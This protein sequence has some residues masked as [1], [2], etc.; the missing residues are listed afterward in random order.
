M[1]L[2]CTDR[3]RRRW[4]PLAGCGRAEESLKN[5]DGRHQVM[6]DTGEGLDRTLESDREYTL[7]HHH[8][9]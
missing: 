1:L 9:L 2:T 4:W 5:A 8:A 6:R 3:P 7:T